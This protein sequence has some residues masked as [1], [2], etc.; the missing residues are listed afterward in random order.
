LLT[1]LRIIKHPTI[2]SAPPVAHEGMD[3]KM[4]AKNI[5]MKNI[6]P[7]VTAVNPVFPPSAGRFG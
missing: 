3:A 4:G 6:T 2:T 1:H 5:E 7:V